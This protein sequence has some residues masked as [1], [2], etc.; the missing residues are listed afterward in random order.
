[1][2]SAVIGDPSSHTALGSISKVTENGLLSFL[3]VPLPSRTGSPLRTGDGTKLPSLSKSMR[4]GRMCSST[5]QC[6]H[7]EFAHCVIGFRQSGHCSAPR[8][9]VPPFLP[10]A[11]PWLAFVVVFL[12]L[13]H[14]A[15][16]S[17][18]QN[19]RQRSETPRRCRLTESGPPGWLTR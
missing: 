10:V 12:S 2:S 15:A 7:E 1:M 6:S 8:I 18:K 17:T 16:N 5:A 19:S 3:P 13:L 9:R 11:P 14:A 4:R